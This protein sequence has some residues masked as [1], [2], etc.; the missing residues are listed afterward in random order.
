[1][2]TDRSDLQR[3]TFSKLNLF[4]SVDCYKLDSVCVSGLLLCSKEKLVI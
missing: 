4:K 2:F 1:M 3:A